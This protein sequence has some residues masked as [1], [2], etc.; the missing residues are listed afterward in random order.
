M[1][2]VEATFHFSA[3]NDNTQWIDLGQ[4]ASIVNRKM[5]RQMNQFVV[6]SLELRTTDAGYLMI[7]RLP[8]HW[9]AVNAIVKAF[10]HWKEQQ[11]QTAEEAG[12]E[13]TQ[14][15]YRDFK[16]FATDAH[17]QQGTGNNWIP[18]DYIPQGGVI[19]G[20]AKYDW[21]PSEI[22]IPN[23]VA[24]ASGSTVDPETWFLHVLGN[25]QTVANNSKGLIK[26]Y[27]ESRA[28]PQQEDPNIVNV[29]DGGL[30]GAMENVG[31]DDPEI[32]ENYQD[33][34]NEAPYVN[35]I[36]PSGDEYYPGGVNNGNSLI[37]EARLTSNAAGNTIRSTHGGFIAN[38]GLLK[39]DPVGIA[40]YSLIVK[41]ATDDKGLITRSLLEAN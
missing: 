21:A 11:D 1:T 34:N 35:D 41:L 22:V 32:I 6:Q 5:H 24:D 40:N 13:S 15:R 18:Y 38:M 16:V 2:A 27:A 31:N 10:H 37:E 3:S 30:Y 14:A 12:I 29:G 9:V 28:R 39:V 26:A 25:D 33:N 17:A 8:N 23:A 4:V 19:P 36:Y 7:S 20:T